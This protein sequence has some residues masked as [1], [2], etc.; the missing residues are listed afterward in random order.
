MEIFIRTDT[1]KGTLLK[2]KPSDTIRRVKERYEKEIN[3][4][5]KCQ[6]YTLGKPQRTLLNDQTLSGYEVQQDCVIHMISLSAD[7]T[8]VNVVVDMPNTTDPLHLTMDSL[9]GLVEIKNAITQQTKIP[10]EFQELTATI[11]KKFTL[12]NTFTGNGDHL[13][14]DG[15]EEAM[16]RAPTRYFNLRITPTTVKIKIRHGE[17]SNDEIRVN[18]STMDTV[19]TLREK[20]NAINFDRPQN[21]RKLIDAKILICGSEIVQDDTRF[22]KLITRWQAGQ[23]KLKLKTGK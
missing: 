6:I 9:D 8:P 20:V 17:D 14:E 22:W 16:H 2:V 21:N 15:H 7:S 4:A 3:M 1:D 18:V 11:D 13:Q 23:Q 12:G 5:P 10:A 19:A